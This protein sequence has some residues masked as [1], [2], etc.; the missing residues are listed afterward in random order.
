MHG[1]EKQ[2]CNS[3]AGATQQGNLGL[4]TQDQQQ[5]LRHSANQAGIYDWTSV[6]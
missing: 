6:E 3:R 2:V 5:A 4:I 1:I